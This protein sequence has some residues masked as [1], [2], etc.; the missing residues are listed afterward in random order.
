MIKHLLSIFLSACLYWH[1]YS[2]INPSNIEKIEG[3]WLGKLAIQSIELR[4]VFRFEKDSIGTMKVYLDSPDQGVNGIPATIRKMN[5]DSLVVQVQSIMAKYYSKIINDSVIQ[6]T[7]KQGGLSLPLEIIR[8]K[9]AFVLKRPQEPKPPFDYDIK[10]VEFI[11]PV[12]GNKLSGTLTS[13]KNGNNLPG[14]V[15]ITGSGAQNRDEEIMGHKPFW[16]IADYLSKNG[17][18]V[19]RYDDRG[20]GKSEGIF[21]DATTLDFAD[22]A[23]AAFNFLKTQANIDSAKTGLIGHS[24]G[25]MIAQIISSRNQD[26]AFIIL[27]AAPGMK[28]DDLLVLQAELIN[29]A[30]GTSEKEIRK[31]SKINKKIYSIVKNEDNEQTAK[32]KIYKI[33]KKVKTGLS[34][35]ESEESGFSEEYIQQI[36]SQINSNW[37]RTFFRLDPVKYLENVKCPVFALN[38]SLDLQVPPDENLSIIEQT[39]ILSGNPKIEIKELDGL[40][41][42]FQPSKTGLPNEYNLI[43]TTFDESTLILILSYITEL[44]RTY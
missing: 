9:Q 15:L 35:E 30:S 17:I 24:E 40:N 38:G 2:Q 10:D 11:N 37:F 6:G 16:V 12:S 22:D 41:H 5:D 34:K 13:P 14:V 27:L 21:S 23:E 31:A 7:F 39:L 42:L 8:Q 36:I 33:L 32:Y 43:E 29:R 26:I 20:V 25:G 1:G 19:L 3:S 28:G 4:I 18:A 44:P